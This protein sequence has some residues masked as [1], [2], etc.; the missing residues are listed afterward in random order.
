[1]LPGAIRACLTHATVLAFV[2]VVAG[3]V[4]KRLEAN[5]WFDLDRAALRCLLLLPQFDGP[6]QVRLILLRQFVAP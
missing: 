6:L 1:M 2:P 3:H 5:W 4:R